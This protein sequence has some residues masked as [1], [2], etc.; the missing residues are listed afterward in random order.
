MGSSEIIAPANDMQTL[1]NAGG[2]NTT[3]NP[4]PK[5][6]MLGE[7][8]PITVITAK[9]NQRTIPSGIFNTGTLYPCRIK[10]FTDQTEV[11]IHAIVLFYD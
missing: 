11:G 1:A 8:K 9:G 2:Y 5:A 6:F 4:S 3:L 7:D 10:R